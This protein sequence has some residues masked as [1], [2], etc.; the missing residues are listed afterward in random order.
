[1]NTWKEVEAFRE[2]FYLVNQLL[3]LSPQYVMVICL[4]HGDSIR[5]KGGEGV[6]R[7][8]EGR[9]G[10]GRGGCGEDPKVCRIFY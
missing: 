9:G 4:T 2:K 6:G 1:M 8:G 3:T 5:G 7:G 10:E